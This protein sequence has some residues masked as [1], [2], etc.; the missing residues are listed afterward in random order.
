MS[1]TFSQWL[2]HSADAEFESFVRTRRDLLQPESPTMA[3]LAAAAS[4]R[5]GV[6]RGIEALDAGTL[7]VFIALAK[8]AR[9]TPEIEVAGIA[10]IDPA[11]AEAAVPRLRD[12][13]LAWPAGGDGDGAGSAGSAESA[14]SAG[15]AVAG[16]WKI[17]SEAITLLP[18]SAAE[19]SRAHPWQIDESSIDSSTATIGQPLI[20]NSEQAAV[21]EVIS[22]LRGLVDELAASPIS[23]LT[24]GGISKR[25]VSRL[26]RTLELGLEQTITLLQAAKS[27]HLIGV[28]DDALDPQWT[29]ADDADSALAGDRADL[30]A[31]LVGAWLR[32]LLD[33]TQLAAGAS[34]N[35]RLTVLAAPKKSLFKG[36]GLSVPAMPLL[37]FA[38]LS[39]LHDIGLGTARSAGWIHAE[40]LRRHPLLPAHEFAMTE[41]VLHT[42][43]TVGLATTPLQQPD[44]FGPS[45]FGLR[46]AAGLDRAMA[47]HA[48]QDPSILPLG[49]SVEALTVPG[50][51]IAAVTEGLGAEVDTV[52]IQSD[53]TAVATGPIEPR[54]HN[55]LR[56]YAVVEARGQGTVYRIDAETIED[57]MQAGLTPE[58]ALAELAE[59]SAEELPSTLEF[60]VQNTASKLRRVRVAGARS[61]LI[62]D[63]PVDLD[64]ILS[65]QA[66]M[67][68]GLERLAPTVAIAQLGPERTMHLLEASDHHALL[69]SAAGPVRK[70]RVITESEPEVSVRRR[71]R[72]SDGHLGEYIRILRSAPATA[73]PVSTD[74]PLGHMDRLREA[75]ETKQRVLIRIADSHG[76]ERTIEM[77]PATLNAGRVRGVVT[78]TGAEASLSVARIVSVTPSP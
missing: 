21:A 54:V 13:G 52:L 65:D 18:T 68:A 66:M 45:R 41:A 60:L 24:S 48:V 43:V 76:K 51:V 63:D 4:S 9:T 39:V 53:L 29:A 17:Q 33:V 2:S 31:G 47:E 46:L 36:Y 73:A 61:V 50:D 72:V 56:K 15:S 23:R 8:A 71:P 57:T 67:P 16:V 69:H 74:E 77:L 55:I 75:A 62:V 5:I 1:M 42:C 20:H 34:E 30:W 58:E 10:H 35:E 25:D 40:V 78:T 19:S 27:L 6:S 70:R 64:V 37:R 59:I 26:A 7:E 12:L 22:S 14:G 49:V 32:D 3:A 11:L 44:H 28:L 38:V